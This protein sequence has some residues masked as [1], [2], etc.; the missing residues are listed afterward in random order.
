MQETYRQPGLTGFELKNQAAEPCAVGVYDPSYEHDSCGVGFIA[1]L[2]NEPRHDVVRDAIR[3]LVNLEH[4]GAVGGDKATGDGAGLL[5]Q[6][7]HDFMAAV[8]REEGITIPA[9]GEYVIPELLGGSSTNMIGRT[10]W[11]EFFQ[12]RD[13]PIASA[14]AVLLILVLVLPI[15]VFQKIAKKEGTG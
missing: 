14:V 7:P 13:W 12:N 9:V 1:S 5:S 6:L 8:C 15:V 11:N 4:R 2:D 3:I 10:L